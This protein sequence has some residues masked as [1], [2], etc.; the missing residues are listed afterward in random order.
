MKY[1]LNVVATMLS[2][3]KLKLMYYQVHIFHNIKVNT[4]LLEMH[5]FFFFMVTT[6]KKRGKNYHE[7]ACCLFFPSTQ[8]SSSTSPSIHH[9]A[10]CTSIS[11]VLWLQQ[12]GWLLHPSSNWSQSPPRPRVSF[13]IE[14]ETAF[15]G[16]GISAKVQRSP[17]IRKSSHRHRYMTPPYVSSRVMR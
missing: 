16:T 15:S 2:C 4:I 9:A 17:R 3:W 11:S 13:K 10:V 12:S 6:E 8:H 5:L 14:E 7:I 1:M